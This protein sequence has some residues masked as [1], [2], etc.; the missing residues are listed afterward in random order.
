MKK[1]TSLTPI[2]KVLNIGAERPSIQQTI[3]VINAMDFA[4]HDD[5]FLFRLTSTFGWE[6]AVVI[7]DELVTGIENA[8]LT[9]S[10]A[11]MPN[12]ED[13]TVNISSSPSNFNDALHLNSQSVECRSLDFWIRHAK[14]QLTY[15]DQWGN[16]P[17]HVRTHDD[18]RQCIMKLPLN[19]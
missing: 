14:S 7:C 11:T 6:E 17:L 2:L 10:S 18:R 4:W 12:Q 8:S 1:T 5:Q 3:E 15:Q 19:L 16:T 9:S 13:G